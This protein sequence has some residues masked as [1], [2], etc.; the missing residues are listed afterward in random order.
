MPRKTR[1]ELDVGKA[2]ITRLN[3]GGSFFEDPGR[4]GF[5]IHKWPGGRVRGRSWASCWDKRLA[6]E[7]AAPAP[8]GSLGALCEQWYAAHSKDKAPSSKRTYRTIIGHITGRLGADTPAQGVTAAMVRT[9]LDELVE[10]PL[11]RTT[12][13]GIRS[14]LSTICEWGVDRELLVA[15]PLRSV[16]TPSGAAR[17]AKRSEDRAFTTEEYEA[18]LDHLTTEHSTVNLMF[19]VM[20]HCGLRPGEARSLRWA[21]INWDARTLRADTAIRETERGT[22][23]PSTTMKTDHK[24]DKAHR[25]IRMTEELATALRRE[26]TEQMARGRGEH[27]FYPHVTRSANK[28]GAARI[29]RVAGVRHLTANEY[30]HTFASLAVDFGTPVPHV[31]AVMGHNDTRMVTNVYA[32]LLTDSADVD[33]SAFLARRPQPVVAQG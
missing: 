33:T 2:E 32:R 14:T 22:F 23:E 12:I 17:T 20:L 28:T 6:R 30:R 15:N 29:A 5:Y 10:V 21:D 31:S 8:G 1:S 19:L 9:M 27:V 18:V 4:P 16:R 26:A 13:D 11:S 7:A 24:T 3:L 25:T